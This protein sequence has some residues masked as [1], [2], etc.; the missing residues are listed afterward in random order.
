MTLDELRAALTGVLRDG[1]LTGAEASVRADPDTVGR[2]FAQADRRLGR[3][4]LPDRPTRLSQWTAGQAGRALLLAALLEAPDPV[5]RIVAVY[6]QGDAAERLAVLKALPL[7]PIGA[8]AAPLL[9]DALRTNDTRL[10]A[11]ALGPYAVHLDVATWRQGVIKCVFMGVPLTYV[12]GLDER[13]DGDLAAMLAALAEER[14]A[15][16]R[17]MPADAVA[18][19][20]RLSPTP[21]RSSTTSTR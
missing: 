2:F 9:H 17:T 21:A 14:I 8:A 4:P 6:Q 1:W 3:E 5:D 18:L 19:L 16:G 10:V 7:L 13:A 12:D 15:A 11:A 20:D